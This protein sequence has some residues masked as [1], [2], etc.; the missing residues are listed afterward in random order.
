MS[1]NMARL[2]IK[3]HIEK[4]RKVEVNKI[5]YASLKLKRIL[6]RNNI[7]FNNDIERKD[8]LELLSN[9]GYEIG[10]NDEIISIEI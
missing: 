1:R 8:A 2:E 4:I 6:E 5:E 7:K 3:S 10:Q 9:I